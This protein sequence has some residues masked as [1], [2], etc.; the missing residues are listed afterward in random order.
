[1]ITA[2][3]IQEV[4]EQEDDLPAIGEWKEEGDWFGFRNSSGLVEWFAPLE[5]LF[6]ST[7]EFFLLNQP[8]ITCAGRDFLINATCEEAALFL[9]RFA[10]NTYA[11]RQQARI[12]QELQ[13]DV[14]GD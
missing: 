9:N 10:E 2:K 1:M 3:R 5:S 13:Y 8:G 14:Y 6:D 12:A 4:L 7:I 11:E